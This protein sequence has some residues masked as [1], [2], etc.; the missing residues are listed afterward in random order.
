MMERVKSVLDSYDLKNITIGTI[1]SHSALQILFGA[2]VEGF[3]TL[4]IIKPDRRP[5]YDA[6]AAARP[7]SY[8]EV[9]DWADILEPKVQQ[10]LIDRNTIIVPH[11]SFIE[12]IGPNNIAGSFHVPVLGNRN[13][14]EWESDRSKQ[15]E[16]LQ[17]A[18]VRL[19]R[20]FPS[21]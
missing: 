8:I 12:Y 19:P 4:G 17:K 16:W 3:K 7:D 5:V 20:E 2:R 6:Y 13:T 14:L 1:C 10:E 9:K 21:P 18:G 11:G 15:R